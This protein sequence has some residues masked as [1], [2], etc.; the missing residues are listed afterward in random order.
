M[1]VNGNSMANRLRMF[2]KMIV[3]KKAEIIRVRD[4]MK[5][6]IDMR[7]AELL[8]ELDGIWRDVEARK[9]T[10][11]EE[12]ERAIGEIIEYKREIE[13]IFLRFN[14][15]AKPLTQISE[16]IE[17]LVN[18][19]IDIELPFVKLDWNVNELR[20][21]INRMCNCLQQFLYTEDTSTQLKWSSCDEGV[22]DNQL[23][24]PQ[25]IAIDSTTD[26]IYVTDRETDRIQIFS[27]HGDWIRCVK[28]ELIMKPENIQFFKDS[29]CIQCYNCVLTL[30]GYTFE[31]ESYKS[32]AFT[33]GGLCEDNTNVYVGVE[34]S[35]ELLVLTLSLKEKRH[36]PLISKFCEQNKTRINGMSIADGEIYVLLSE[37]EYP[38]QTFSKEGVLLRCVIE[39][40]QLGI[41]Y[42]FCLDQQLNIITSDNSNSQV[43]IFSKEGKIIYKFGKEGTEK[44]EFSDLQG[45]A[46]DELGTLITVDIRSYN[47]LQAFYHF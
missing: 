5:Q 28:H 35:M 23:N 43:K 15:T 38:I 25:G 26:L 18:E 20:E 19:D 1:T 3:E 36:T 9:E 39:K 24:S 40:E 45:L 29:I 13:G 41:C 30:N 12:I 46:V 44:G 22:D 31:L 33:L 11:R 27:K 8:S 42:C 37:T 7:S 16:R 10:R 6:L 32:Y 21:S 47:M 14:C 17:S 2:E 4:E 34:K